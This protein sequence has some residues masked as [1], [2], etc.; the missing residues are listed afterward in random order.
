MRQIEGFREKV[1]TPFGRAKLIVVHEAALVGLSTVG[2]VIGSAIGVW[3][4]P[5]AEYTHSIFYFAAGIMLAISFLDLI[6]E[7]IALG[8][9]LTCVIGLSIGGMGLWSLDRSFPHVH[10]CPACVENQC[11]L[12]HTANFL[13]LAIALHNFPEGMAIAVGTAT[14]IGDSFVIATAI[15]LHN[16]PEGIC[17]SAPHYHAFGNRWRSF[18]MSSMSALPIVAGF[19]AARFLFGVI[20]MST[21]S[22]LVGATAGLMIYISANELMPTAQEGSGRQ[23]IFF[24]MAGIVS[25]ILLEVVA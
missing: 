2:P 22:L 24:F 7:S 4:R 15:A 11:P 17:T 16:I 10:S 5:S 1:R 9:P 25:V 21:M 3:K 23:T 13:I 19:L 20:S 12:G 6:P 14:D 18:A 8:S